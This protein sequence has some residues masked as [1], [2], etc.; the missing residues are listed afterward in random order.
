MDIRIY[1]TNTG[2]TLVETFIVNQDGGFEEEGEYQIAGVKGSGSQIKWL[3][4]IR[5]V[6]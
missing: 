2:R 1:N 4:S 3:S 5:Q 6:A